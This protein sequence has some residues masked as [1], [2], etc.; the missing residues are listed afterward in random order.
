MGKKEL[1]KILEFRPVPKDKECASDINAHH[2]EFLKQSEKIVFD[3][4]R[5][6][7]INHAIS[8]GEM[9]AS[10][11]YQLDTGKLVKALSI[12]YVDI[13]SRYVGEAISS[14]LCEEC[15][16]SQDNC[17]ICKAIVDNVYFPEIFYYIEKLGVMKQPIPLIDDEIIE[18][19]NEERGRLSIIR[20]QEEIED[21]I[22]GN[23]SQTF[24]SRAIIGMIL[25][26]GVKHLE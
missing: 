16:E 24:L 18:V 4:L 15:T 22:Y 11:N 5:R 2:Q 7:A 19:L 8:V 6:G 9:L 14:V 13:V 21:D 1:G 25:T 10:F 20:M 12:G 23:M 26:G 3:A 17:D